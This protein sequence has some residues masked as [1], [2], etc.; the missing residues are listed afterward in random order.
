MVKTPQDKPT[1]LPFPPFVLHPPRTNQ[2]SYPGHHFFCSEDPP[3]TNP[4]I[5]PGHHFHHS[6]YTPPRTNQTSYPGH[7][8]FCGEDPLDKP[9]PGHHFPPFTI[10]YRQCQNVPWTS[11]LLQTHKLPPPPDIFLNTPLDTIYCHL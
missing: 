4:Y 6:S 7:H 2:T 9:T 11:L 8:F 10:A 5:H 3:K 1:Y